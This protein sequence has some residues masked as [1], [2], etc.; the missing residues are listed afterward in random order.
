MG[1]H[2]DEA[3][4]TTTEQTQLNYH[5][6]TLCTSSQIEGAVAPTNSTVYTIAHFIVGKKPT[7]NIEPS[8]FSTLSGPLS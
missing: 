4:R 2:L 8:I 7:V 5:P 6:I 3:S 1:S